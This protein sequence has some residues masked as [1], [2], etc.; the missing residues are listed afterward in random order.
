MIISNKMI[1]CNNTNDEHYKSLYFYLDY[2]LYYSLTGIHLTYEMDPKTSVPCCEALQKGTYL[3][4]T[5]E[6]ELRMSFR[7]YPSLF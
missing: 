5:H 2:L 1:K 6:T 3:F 4:C 7:E